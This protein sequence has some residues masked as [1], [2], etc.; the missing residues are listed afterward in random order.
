VIFAELLSE[1]DR[2][3]LIAVLYPAW[4]CMYVRTG[5]FLLIGWILVPQ[6]VHE[7]GKFRAINVGSFHHSEAN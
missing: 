6:F 4:A 1:I 2:F 7:N 3:R 5:I